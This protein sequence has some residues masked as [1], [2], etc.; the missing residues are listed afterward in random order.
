MFL[1]FTKNLCHHLNENIWLI[2]FIQLVSFF[3]HSSGLCTFV[4]GVS[5]SKRVA[6]DTGMAAVRL[7]ATTS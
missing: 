6:E 2:I 5:C 7:T 4:S 1:A 3:P